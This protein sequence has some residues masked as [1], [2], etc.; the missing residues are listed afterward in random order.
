MARIKNL[1]IVVTYEG[2]HYVV[3]DKGIDKNPRFELYD[4]ST[5][6]TIKKSNNPTDFD[7]YVY[8]KEKKHV[9]LDEKVKK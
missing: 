6:Q 3:N 5:K 2:T 7:E 4:L 1:N 8:K 9:E